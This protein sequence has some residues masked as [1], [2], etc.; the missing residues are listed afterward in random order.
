VHHLLERG[1]IWV[2]SERLQ[3][4]LVVLVPVANAIEP[5]CEA[6]LQ[7]LRAR[8]IKVRVF[9]GASAIDQVR[10]MMVHDALRDGFTEVLWVDA[11]VGFEPADVDMLLSHDQ[12][13]VCGIYPKKATRAFACHLLPGTRE[14]V[15]G[16]EGGLLEILY[17]AGGFTL[18]RSAVYVALQEKLGLPTCN[19]QFGA[20]LVPY[21][22]P[23]VKET[24]EGPWYLAEDYAFSERARQA[25]FSV[26][27]DTR[28]RL[29]HIG[30]YAYQWE[31]AGSD[32]K[33]H[34]RYTFVVKA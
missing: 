19:A 20:P 12:P 28:I 32:L 9:R 29:R 10:S 21:Y 7:K 22:L 13:L 33:R 11:D 26:Y 18:V 3:L 25:G 2:L 16:E 30:R 14:L 5:E 31:D 6:S 27:A 34:P 24:P 8:G 17:A 15:F 4:S 23:M 1:R